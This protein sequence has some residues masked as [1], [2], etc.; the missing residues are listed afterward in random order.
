MKKRSLCILFFFLLLRR[1]TEKL[2]AQTTSIQET[3]TVHNISILEKKHKADSLFNIG[4][5]AI[6]NQNFK[7]AIIFL[8]LSVEF[9]KSI[10]SQ[11]EIGR[12]SH[13]MAVSYYYLGDY[14]NALKFYDIGA[15]MF[16]KIDYK[17][18][19]AAI[20]NNTGNIY[21]TQGDYLKALD[22]FK[23]AAILFNTVGDRKNS[24]TATHNVGLI[25]FKVKDTKNALNYF[26]QAYSIQK[27]LNDIKTIPSS[28]GAIADVYAKE[29]NDKKALDYYKQSLDI[30][31]RENDK[32]LKMQSL[33]DLGIFL[34]KKLDY[35]QALPILIKSLRYSEEID[36]IEYQSKALISIG[37][38]LNETGKSSEAVRD[39][40]KGLNLA[41]KLKSFRYIKDGCDC[42]YQSYKS[43]GKAQQALQYYERA[44]AYDDSLNLTETSNKLLGMEF[45]KQQLVDSIAYVKK[46]HLTQLKHKE[47][48]R[49]REKQR[50]IIIGSLCVMLLVAVGLW[51]Q[52]RYVRKSREA[53]KVEK[54]RS[55][56]L[57]LNI[58]PEEIA[59]ELKEKGEVNARNYNMVSILFTDFKSFTQTA[60]KMSP[61]SLVEELNTCF[62]AFDLI[63]ATYQI[64]KIKTIGDAYMAA[65][66]IPIPDANA[67]KNTV[68]AGLE[69]QAFML[70]RAKELEQ[71]GRPAFEMRL[72]IHAGPIVAGIVGVK[73]FQYDVWGDAVNTASR[74][75]SSG[76]V[77]KVNISET[78]YQLIK[79]EPC[80][81]FEYRGSIPAKGK[82]DIAMY[83]VE[84]AVDSEIA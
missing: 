53:I 17:R 48:V 4:E 52:L 40:Q 84:K 73:K 66:G 50:N 25:Y 64:E 15:E 10:N 6:D 12:C 36:N 72:G 14:F 81:S 56:A 7:N 75:E 49:Q 77:G 60:E 65:G 24:A 46:E 33:S 39:C 70:N 37:S 78:L 5:N 80:F 22:R 74:M 58:L 44:N 41:D 23:R 16:R 11:K 13:Y 62:K 43:L 32:L 3:H 79:D 20:Y 76:V 18:G 55:E 42:L 83:F 51:G 82:G 57:L 69:M 61:E 34:Y 30:A 29:G 31:N 9:Y 71:L 63:T 1:G 35:K 28:L 68:L 2:Y 26:Q 19:I 27:E 21:S 8:S 54:D 45:Q 47:E 59:E 67:L 38:I